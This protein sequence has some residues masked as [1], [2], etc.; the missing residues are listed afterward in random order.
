MPGN[1]MDPATLL[2][3]DDLWSMP[4]A[5]LPHELW[6]G[7]LRLVT[8]AGAAHGAVCSRLL[9]ALSRHVYA[10][11]LGELFT[12][13]T[14]FL[15]ERG[16]DTVLCPDVAFVSRG[17]LPAGGIGLRFMDLVPDLAI[18]VLSPSDRPAEMRAKVAEY[19][20]LGVRAIWV[21]D[22]AA[23]GVRV[24]ARDAGQGS[25]VTTTVLA[26][27]DLLNGGDVIPGFRC[28]VAELFSS[29]RR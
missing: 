21:L 28:P 12:E 18:E 10:H 19:L 16:P 8:P 13:A 1:P 9:A 2:T 22:P 3:A 6:R 5:D 15:L 29:L 26:E 4:E 17:R 14:G 23:R 27:D 7:A 24:H 20:R 11:D 25:H